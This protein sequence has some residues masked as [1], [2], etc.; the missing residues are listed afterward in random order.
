[1]NTENLIE[2]AEFLEQL[3]LEPCDQFDIGRFIERFVDGKGCGTAACA[4]GWMALHNKFGLMEWNDTVKLQHTARSGFVAARDVFDITRDE[5]K[6]LFHGSSYRMAQYKV[7][8]EMVAARMR[9]LAAG[10]NIEN[11]KESTDA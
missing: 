11:P 8:K 5:S 4:L 1:M 7:T 6:W 2:G 3:E 9:W 10:G